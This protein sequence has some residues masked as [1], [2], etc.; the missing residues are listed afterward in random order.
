MREKRNVYKVLLGKLEVNLNIPD[1]SLHYRN[2]ISDCD[3]LQVLL[4]KFGLQK[5]KTEAQTVRVPN[6]HFPK[7]ILPRN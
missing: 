3:C 7:F 4:V 6:P 1:G 5:L 2:L